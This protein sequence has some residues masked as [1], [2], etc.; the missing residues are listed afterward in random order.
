MDLDIL[1]SGAENPCPFFFFS[2]S[3]FSISPPFLLFFG[4]PVFERKY[5]SEGAFVCFQMMDFGILAPP[6]AV[7]GWL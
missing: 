3:S 5:L 4:E 1:C 6:L 2:L 7:Q